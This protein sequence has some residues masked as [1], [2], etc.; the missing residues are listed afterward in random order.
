MLQNILP[1]YI[2]CVRINTSFIPYGTQVSRL[3]TESFIP[4]F[5]LAVIA[6]TLSC[7]EAQLLVDKINE[8]KIKEVTR[9]EMI[10]V[11]IEETP[12]CWDAKDD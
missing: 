10:S 12:Y 3:G 4:M 9:A 1:I 11:V 5:H 8:F 6:T 2:I 7:V